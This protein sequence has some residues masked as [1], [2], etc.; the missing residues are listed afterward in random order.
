MP[1]I[2]VA[3]RDS[4]LSIGRAR[5]TLATAEDRDSVFLTLLRAARA[6]ARWA[7]L[8]T[9]QGGAAI[10]RVALAEPG[11]ETLQ[12]T[13]ILIPLD[14]VSP[15]RNV[16]SSQQ[17]HIGPL[18]SGDPGIDAMLLRMGGPP[19]P[20][21]ALVMPIVLRERVIA[22]MV[23]HRSHNDIR[24]VDVTEL[25]PLAGV[26]SD[27]IG[28]LIVK[29]KA[30]GYRAPTPTAGIPTANEFESEVDTKRIVVGAPKGQDES[31]GWAVPEPEDR[32]SMPTIEIESGDPEITT[33]VAPPR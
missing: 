29:H 15:F 8:M 13:S 2:N 14:A 24:I 19:T 21:S 20:T 11:S 26:A 30:A 3:G 25:L 6:R 23:A 9:V 31:G 7:G 33:S 22:L 10:G 32:V 5:E 18:V 27:A 28:R 12:I 17:P 1:P 4:P 16:V